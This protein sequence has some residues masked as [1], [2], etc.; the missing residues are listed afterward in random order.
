MTKQLALQVLE[1]LEQLDIENHALRVLIL[2]TRHNVDTEKIDELLAETVRQ[3]S[4]RSVVREKWLPLR[5]QVEEEPNAE[6]ALRQVLLKL[7]ISKK[8]N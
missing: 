8:V 6:E 7:P 1:R 2:M 5:Q 3:T 4:V